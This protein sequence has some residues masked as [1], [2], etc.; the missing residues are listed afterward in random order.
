M[1]PDQFFMRWREGL[2]WRRWLL[3]ID[4]S[5]MEPADLRSSTREHLFRPNT[6]EATKKRKWGGRND[7]AKHLVIKCVS[8]K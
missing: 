3:E 7:E 6:G 5:P 1:A 2:I 4:V 8:S